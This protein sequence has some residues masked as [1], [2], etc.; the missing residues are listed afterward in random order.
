LR[1]SIRNLIQ[2][3]I[4]GKSMLYVLEVARNIISYLKIFLHEVGFMALELNN[5]T[6]HSEDARVDRLLFLG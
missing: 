3:E 2:I 6:P 1:V 4:G 5:I